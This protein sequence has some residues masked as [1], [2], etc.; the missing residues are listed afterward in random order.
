M[1]ET[2]KEEAQE[3]AAD[4]AGEETNIVGESDELEMAEENPSI[5]T[6]SK[7]SD[8]ELR[9]LLGQNKELAEV[10]KAVAELK[11][12]KGE[13]R[14][15]AENRIEGWFTPKVYPGDFKFLPDDARR[16][17]KDKSKEAALNDTSPSS[18]L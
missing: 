12:L 2:L 6:I 3:T 11:T 15:Y 18:V 1:V 9:D 10:K 7:L 14:K 17:A 16:A 8:D 5:E 13:A 4:E